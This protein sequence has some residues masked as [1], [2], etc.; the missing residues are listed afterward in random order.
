MGNYRFRLSDMIPNS[1][2]HKLRDMNSRTKSSRAHHHHHQLPPP[3]KKKQSPSSSSATPPHSS[4]SKS[5]PLPDPP[6]P[7]KSYHFARELTPP[8]PHHHFPSPP[9]KSAKQRRPPRRARRSSPRLV[10]SSVSAGCSCRA[11][12]TLGSFWTK[13]EPVPECSTSPPSDASTASDSEELLPVSDALPQLSP[14]SCGGGVVAHRSFDQMVSWSSSSCRCR[15][16]DSDESTDRKQAKSPD[17]CESVSTEVELPPILTKPAN[18]SDMVKN[19]KNRDTHEPTEGRT[20]SQLTV[21]V[22]KAERL[23][24]QE[25]SKARRSFSVSSPG[26]K[27]RINSPRLASTKR[28]QSQGTHHHHRPGRKSA[29]SPSPSNRRRRSVSDSFA[30]MKSSVDPQSDFRD[31]MMEMIVENDIRASKDLEELLACYLSL[32]SDEYH[33]LIIK[34]FKQIWFDLN[35]TRLK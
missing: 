2:L 4:G 8:H 24:V 9:R 31:S 25:H 15:V 29:S 22:V 23:T 30:V 5:N 13:P 17:G 20:T 16:L 14:E 3:T 19:M 1:W 11:T 7:R 34:V 35:C 12:A 32:N 33:D 10:A 26:V 18:F 21:R 28:A 27:L 6:H